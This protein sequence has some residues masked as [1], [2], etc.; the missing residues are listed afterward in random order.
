VAN[1]VLHPGGDFERG[2][3]GW[4][5]GGA[6]IV[7][8]NE[9][10]KVGGATHGKSLAI[11]AGATVTTGSICVG[12]EHP[13]LRLFSKQ[14][15]GTTLGR[16]DVEVLFE[17][18]G[19]NVH[20]LPIGAVGQGAWAPSQI[21]VLAANLLAG[22]PGERTAVAFRFSAQGGSFQIDDVYV[23]PWSKR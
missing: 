14:T 11:P 10:W 1:Y 7:N 8:G 2:A 12:I 17:D 20:S 13:T 3:A 18:A 23:D 5:L 4:D 15:S 6:S 21:M 22:L 16:L 19:G 9:P